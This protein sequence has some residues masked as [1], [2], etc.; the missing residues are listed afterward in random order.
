LDD[1]RA[2][3]RL[4]AALPAPTP[5]A[6]NCVSTVS[7]DA[8]GVVRRTGRTVAQLV[9]GDRVFGRFVAPAGQRGSPTE[10]TSVPQWWALAPMPPGLGFADAAACISPGLAAL[11]A[12]D[13]VQPQPGD[14]VVVICGT[15]P[16][17]VLAIQLARARGAL[18]TT[19]GSGDSV[20]MLR[21]L[22]AVEV[23]DTGDGDLNAG[24]RRRHPGGVSAVIDAVGDSAA[25]TLRAQLLRAGGRLA[26]VGGSPRPA[27]F[28]RRRA[29]AV[30][31]LPRPTTARL[32]ELA[33][34]V[35]DGRLRLGPLR[36]E[37]WPF[38]EPAVLPRR[39][40]SLASGRSG[41]S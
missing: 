13:A 37:A 7:M 24:I 17:S 28:A 35:H 5:G 41:S 9:I 21:A 33:A 8:A 38:P 34:A 3:V 32:L 18:V 31:V 11:A 2:L 23:M 26:A 16:V 36:Q 27:D 22:G 29:T 39:R 15:H 25:V 4:H 14:R 20:G 12:I 6:P 40:H 1:D 30:R 10:Y 19:S